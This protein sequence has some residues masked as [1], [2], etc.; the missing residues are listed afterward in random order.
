MTKCLT[1]CV[2]VYAIFLL[3]ISEGL[4]FRRSKPAQFMSVDVNL[5]THIFFKSTVTNPHLFS[6]TVP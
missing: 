1:S 4:I 2:H 3:N 5:N 6:I